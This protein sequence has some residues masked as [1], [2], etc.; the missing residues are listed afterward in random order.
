MP[1]SE[2]TPKI[3]NN[4][5]DVILQVIT[6]EMLNNERSIA[7]CYN[8]CD[9]VPAFLQCLDTIS[10]NILYEIKVSISDVLL[11]LRGNNKRIGTHGT[12]GSVCKLYKS[13]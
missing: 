10:M 13:Q 8:F 9:K 4:I 11:G 1:I 2:P 3:Q 6:G 5:L 12:Y 7:V